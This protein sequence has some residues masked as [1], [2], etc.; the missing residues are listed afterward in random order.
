MPKTHHKT[1][2]I[3]TADNQKVMKINTGIRTS[4]SSNP[5]HDIS[6]DDLT[7]NQTNMSSTLERK[8]KQLNKQELTVPEKPKLK[9]I[10]PWL[11][12][13]KNAFVR[14]SVSLK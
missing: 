8:T 13:L 4:E 5:K 1:Y 9:H 10:I 14:C 2:R 6:N 7:L 11:I 12:Y 3:Y